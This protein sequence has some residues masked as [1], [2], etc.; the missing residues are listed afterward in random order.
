MKRL[1]GFL[2]LFIAMQLS[3]QSL[4]SIERDLLPHFK[5]ITSYYSPLDER[6]PDVI[7]NENDIFTAK[8]IYYLK[9]QPKTLTHK[10]DSLIKEGLHI[11]SSA[12]KNFR[13]YSWQ[14][15]LGGRDNFV[16]NVY[17]FHNDWICGAES[18]G[19]SGYV[20]DIFEATLNGKR[21]YF[22]YIQ[23]SGSEE[24]SEQ[25]L[26]N[27]YISGD[28]L[29]TYEPIFKLGE[30]PE[31]SISIIFDH[32]SVDDPDHIIEFDPKTKTFLIQSVGVETTKGTKEIEK[33]K[34]SGKYFE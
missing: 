12:D 28:K 2:I 20:I 31:A 5:I 1:T 21:Y 15:N 14:F 29:V 10:F 19:Q 11:H 7:F 16:Y 3:A 22:P 9:K 27:C 26:S 18:A 25:E 30:E 6:E 34:F 17:Q 8:L 32:F 33:Y 23:L 13:I 4:K 24:I